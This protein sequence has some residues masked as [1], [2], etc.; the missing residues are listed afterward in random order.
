V[1]YVSDFP[2]I[3]Y[4]LYFRGC[5]PLEKDGSSLYSRRFDPC[6]MDARDIERQLLPRAETVTTYLNEQRIESRVG[7]FQD[8]RPS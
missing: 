7:R 6:E 2:V 5:P 4:Q 1:L 8:T 3:D